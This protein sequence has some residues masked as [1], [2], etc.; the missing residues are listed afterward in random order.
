LYYFDDNTFDDFTAESW[1]DKKIDEDG[2]Q[3]QLT[4]KGLKMYG[5]HYTY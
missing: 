5:D 1:I 3:R 2:N 4:G